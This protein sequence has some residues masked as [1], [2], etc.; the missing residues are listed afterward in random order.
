MAAPNAAGDRPKEIPDFMQA[1][2]KWASPVELQSI[3]GPSDLE[4]SFARQW[5]NWWG[6]AAAAADCDLLLDDWRE[7][8]EDVTA[9]MKEAVKDL[10][11][12]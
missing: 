6:T 2:R 1:G 4:E 5:W 9:V 8:V 7:A 10:H 11:P 12:M 3:C